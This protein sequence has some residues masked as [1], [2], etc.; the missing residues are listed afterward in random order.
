MMDEDLNRHC[1]TDIA[2]RIDVGLSPMLGNEGLHFG[3]I[4]RL[5]IADMVRETSV[6]CI[7]GSLQIELSTT[8]GST[9]STRVIP[10]LS[11][12]SALKILDEDTRS[13]IQ[14]ELKLRMKLN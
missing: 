9:A 6:H 2:V 11:I 8:G 12:K 14:G 10:K 13:N 1:V 4:A 5:M 7:L 3:T